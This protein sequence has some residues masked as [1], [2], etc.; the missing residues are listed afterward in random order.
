MPSTQAE[1]KEKRPK[2]IAAKKQYRYIYMAI[3]TLTNATPSVF[4]QT[5]HWT[6]AAIIVQYFRT[7]TCIVT[8]SRTSPRP[9]PSS[10]AA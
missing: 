10:L 1:C 4:H 6:G 3:G 2:V 8:L 9:M 7:K 5:S